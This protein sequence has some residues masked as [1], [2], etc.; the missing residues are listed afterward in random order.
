MFSVLMAVYYRDIP[1]LVEAAVRSIT[2]EQTIVPEE[3]VIVCDGPLPENL[4]KLI[5][6]MAASEFNLEC[7]V[8]VVKLEENKGLANALNVGLQ[9]C[10]NDLIIRM[11]SDDIAWPKR[12]EKTKDL[13][14]KYENFAI[15]GFAYEIFETD[16]KRPYGKREVQYEVNSTTRREFFSTPINHPTI[17]LRKNLIAAAGGY[18]TLVGRFEDW[19]LALSV[20]S[21]GYKIINSAEVVLS[22]RAPRDIMLRRGGY[23][24]ARE[25]IR[26][27]VRMYREGA[28]P[29]YACLLNIMIR[30]PVR[31]IPVWFRYFLYK[32]FIW[33]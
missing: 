27:L 4:A 15:Y 24:Y 5:E 22:F 10:S 12:L 26:A 3:I 8:V 33:R 11:D 21:K 32:A 31:I 17:C 23:G 20:R 13:I 19:T 7:Q 30:F 25:E 9:V 14:E 29:L 16:V 28:M 2:S 6:R 18:S 1:E